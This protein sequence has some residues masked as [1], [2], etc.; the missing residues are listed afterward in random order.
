[1]GLQDMF[2]VKG[3]ISVDMGYLDMVQNGQINNS[4]FMFSLIYYITFYIITI[5]YILNDN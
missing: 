3:D 5:Y 2:Q 4:F 1:M